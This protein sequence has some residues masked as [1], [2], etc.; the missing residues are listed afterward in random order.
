MQLHV[1]YNFFNQFRSDNFGLIY[2]GNFT[3]DITSILI[4]VSEN[5]INNNGELSKIRK[6]V[7]FLLAEC[8]QNIVRHGE[9][10]QQNAVFLKNPNFFAMRNCGSYYLITSGNLITSEHVDILREKLDHVNELTAEELKMLRREILT[11]RELSEKGGA[12][13]GLI[14]MARKSGRKLRYDFEKI[15]DQYSFFFLQIKLKNVGS[16]QHDEILPSV[17][18]AKILNKLVKKGN[19]YLVH[20]DNFT[21]ET[22]MPVLKMVERN[23][24]E[25]DITLTVK[26]TAYFVLLEILQ[27]I[28]K[29]A[30]SQNG[31]REGL[32]IIG[33]KE[34]SYFIGAGNYI[35]PHEQEKL[36]S[37]IDLMN[38]LNK[39]ELSD[40][41]RKRLRG[42]TLTEHGA[43]LGLI[44]IAR[45]S[46]DKL[47]ATYKKDNGK[48]FFSLIV[49]L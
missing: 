14:E 24:Q 7:N 37:N 46:S 12:G 11:T 32:F 13:L 10:L 15:D 42:G 31:T 18:R 5:N 3:D 16:Q 48:V 21:Q 36:E 19:I 17:E 25:L 9:S 2:H 28:S 20:K 4:D 34:E 8:F 38:K 39:K 40:L 43:G 49:K 29:H 6:K 27:N 47:Q 41:Y 35:Y 23:M 33:K 44:D 30:Y 26:K 1:I 45:E 22:V